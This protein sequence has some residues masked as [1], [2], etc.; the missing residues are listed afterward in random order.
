[1]ILMIVSLVAL[2][3]FAVGICVFGYALLKGQ[4]SER[5]MIISGVLALLGIVTFVVSKIKG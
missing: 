2:L 3:I 1:M 5:A 4:L